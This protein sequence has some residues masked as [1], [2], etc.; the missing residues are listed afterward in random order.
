MPDLSAP[1]TVDGPGPSSDT[2]RSRHL[3]LG[4]LILGATILGVSPI[5]VR[6]SD[7]GPTA[8]AFHRVFLALPLLFLWRRIERGRTDAGPPLAP[9]ALPGLAF[10]GLLFAGDLG[11]WHWSL[12]FTTVANATLLANF[13]P[14]F[15]V[16]G[17]FLLFGERVSVR[18]L[19]GMALAIGGAALLMGQ[20]FDLG[21][22]RLFGDGLGLITGMFF[23]SYLL[24]VGRLRARFTTAA[25]MLWSTAATAAVLLP[26]TLLAGESLI[27]SGAEGWAVL[28]SL[29][30]LVHI[31][32]QGLVAYA[33]A[34]LPTTFSSVGLLIEPTVAAFIAWFLFAEVLGPWQMTG[35]AVILFGIALCRRASQ[36][37]ASR[38]P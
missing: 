3:A 11:F 18:F 33:L 20:S 12:K 1:M 32:G 2:K 9:A 5:L 29:A 38:V 15:V 17:G 8:S 13:A 23:G 24:A 37:V 14:I 6:L 35:A 26:A 21:L 10:A 4:A 36:R 25:I 22:D 19:V 28:L 30:L 31:G 27:P 34:H 16:L 7:L